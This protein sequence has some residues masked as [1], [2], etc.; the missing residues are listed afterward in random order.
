MST[1][2]WRLSLLVKQI[3]TTTSDS[4][5]QQETPT[6]M[7]ESTKHPYAEDPPSTK[8]TIGQQESAH[9]EQV[10]NVEINS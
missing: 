5:G 1:T 3:P 4:D 9:K 10:K 6:T 2:C 7:K 8:D